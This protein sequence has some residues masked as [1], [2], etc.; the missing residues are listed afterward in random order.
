[1]QG[2][3]LDSLEHAGAGVVHQDVQRAE[4]GLDRFEK[5]LHLVP[6]RYIG[7]NAQDVAARGLLQFGGSTVH[8]FARTA[9]NRHRR[10]GAKKGFGNG[11]PDSSRAAGNHRMFSSEKKFHTTMVEK[12][13]KSQ[14]SKVKSA[15][16]VQPLR[17]RGSGATLGEDVPCHR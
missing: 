14:K 7:Y 17:G 11:A 5:E 9:A 15:A 8:R 1:F 13:V 2:Q 10:A 6:F 3:I 16:A 4:T 12:K